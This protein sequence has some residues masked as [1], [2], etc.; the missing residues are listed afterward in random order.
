MIL[1]C[2]LVF[3]GLTLVVSS[4]ATAYWLASL[5]CAMTV[6]GCQSAGT[7][8]FFGLMFSLVGIVFWATLALGV[9]ML[10]WGFRVK[11]HH[12]RKY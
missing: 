3:F 11:S 5:S 9:F 1:V 12:L 2:L 6:T 10:W 8:L 7:E 4:M